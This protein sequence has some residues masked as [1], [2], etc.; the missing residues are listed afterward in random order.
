MWVA[1]SEVTGLRTLPGSLCHEQIK[2]SKFPIHLILLTKKK[3]KEKKVSVKMRN[4][5]SNLIWVVLLIS[6]SF[7][8]RNCVRMFQRSHSRYNGWCV[9]V[10]PLSKQRR[11]DT[12]LLFL[13]PVFIFWWKLVLLGAR[14]HNS[15]C[16]LIFT[17]V[18]RALKRSLCSGFDYWQTQWDW[19][20]P[21]W[22]LGENIA[23][24]GRFV[25][26]WTFL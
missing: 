21:Y 5:K 9:T 8:S 19:H 3:K 14:E 25:H 18:G 4:M 26:A 22:Y 1:Q 11:W 7:F 12:G 20:H 13:H 16:C 10:V 24:D 17:V 2:C 23:K 15:E 6:C